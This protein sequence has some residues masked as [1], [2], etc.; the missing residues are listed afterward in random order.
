MRSASRFF[1]AALLLTGDLASAAPT[2]PSADKINARIARDV[3]W[4]QTTLHTTKCDANA[5]AALAAAAQAWSFDPARPGNEEERA[6][7]A[8]KKAIK[9]DCSDGLTRYVY[10]RMYRIAA[11]ESTEEAARLAREA[12][13]AL[14][15]DDSPAIFKLLGHVR[16]AET[17]IEDAR[18]KNATSAPGAMEHLDAALALWPKVAQSDIPQNVIVDAFQHE[19][20]ADRQLLKDRRARAASILEAYAKKPVILQLLR[21]RLAIDT[22]WDARGTATIDRTTSTAANTFVARLEDAQK[23]TLKLQSLDPTSPAV[24]PLMLA[25][26]LG[27]NCD[28][29]TM[30]AWFR[31]GLAL[32]PG[33]TGLW[34][35]RLHHLEPRWNGSVEEML[36]VGREAVATK[37]WALRTPFVLIFAHQQLSDDDPQYFENPQVCRDVRAIYEPFLKQYPD[38]HYERSGYASLLYRCHDLAGTNREIRQLGAERRIGPFLTKA[39]FDRIKVEAALNAK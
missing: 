8:A 1:L 6:W 36:E 30:D 28:R 37:Q 25:V 27:T 3:Q 18:A 22:A 16:A 38:A 21:A 14:D 11:M 10:A 33:N 39:K 12:A 26:L 34:Y 32:D 5:N 19:L 23:E 31:Y 35:A 15:H 4:Y 24:A 9:G 13:A 2:P 17:I 29:A 7:Q 20:D